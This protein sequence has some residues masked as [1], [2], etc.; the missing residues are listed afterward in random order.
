MSGDVELRRIQPSDQEA[1]HDWA[2]LP[3]SCRYQAWGPNSVEQTR[4]FVN[5]SVTAWTADPVRDRMYVAVVD[6]E[7]VGSGAL[8]IRDRAHG[9]GEITYLVHPR[10]WGRGL[11]TA[12]A[13]E[14][15]RI[16]FAEQGLHRIVGTCDP[17]NGGSATIL[18]RVGMTYEG[19]SRHTMRV[20]DGWRDSDLYSILEPEWEPARD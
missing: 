2:R 12:T 7:V 10:R 1:V 16:G 11:G 20:G 6:G 19:R 5:R 8:H 3:E 4:D 14:L 13:R 18:R 17:R 9:Q 15:L